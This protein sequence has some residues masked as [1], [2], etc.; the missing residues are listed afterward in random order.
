M[1]SQFNN[2]RGPASDTAALGTKDTKVSAVSLI[3]ARELSSLRQRSYLFF[4]SAAL[5]VGVLWAPVH[6]LLVFA[7]HSEFSYIPLIPVITAF[8]IAI[9]R[10]GV[11]AD[12]QPSL[13]I[14]GLIV[15]TGILL[16][17]AGTT[18]RALAPAYGL[19][20]IGLALVTTFLGLFIFAYGTGAARKAL[21]PLCLL[22]F[23]IPAPQAAT[24]RVIACLQHGS[25][26]LAYALFGI[27]GVPA[28]RDGMSISLPH[29]TIEVAPQCSGIRSSVSL[30]ILSL[31]GAHLYL[32]CVSNKIL[33]V[34]L[35]IPLSILKN[36]I[37]IVTLSMLA[38]YVDPMFIKG[39]IHHR[40]GILFFFLAFTLLV[41]VVILMRRFEKRRGV[42]DEKVRYGSAAAVPI[43]RNSLPDAVADYDSSPCCKGQGG[44]QDHESHRLFE[45]NVSALGE[46]GCRPKQ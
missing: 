16:T 8:L 18:V 32:R 29:L 19:T 30:L 1:D 22:L 35:L 44:I 31:A 9:R 28:L 20:F 15:I 12:S 13:V 4:A 26:V 6:R 36:A 40:G 46:W 11:F 25:A 21:L 39:S 38:I 42:K 41:P 3:E 45:S 34:S 27:I 23:M 17:L 14:G 2:Q 33:L 43:R 10:R 5:I 7:A 24:D 37:R